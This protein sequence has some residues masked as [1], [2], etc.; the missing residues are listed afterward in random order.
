MNPIILE[1][2][3]LTCSLRPAEIIPK[4]QP[5]F[6]PNL[7]IYYLDFTLC[8]LIGNIFLILA[9]QQPDWSAAQAACVIVSAFILFR[10]T[11]FI[12]E[13][14]H[15]SKSLKGFIWY[16]NLLHGFLHKIPYY[17]YTTHR[18]HHLPETYGT[19]NDP[20]YEVLGDK[21][22]FYNLFFA[23]LILMALQPVFMMVRWGIMP[24][25]LPFIGK[26]ARMGI[27]T[28][29]SA[30]A[31]NIR[32]QRPAPSDVEKKDW[33]MQDAC[34]LFYSAVTVVLFVAGYLP[35]NLLAIWY[36]SVYLIS[37]VNYYRTML[38]H[39]YFTGFDSTNHKQQVIDSITYVLTPFNALFFPVGLGYH[40]LHHMF[41]QIPY[42]NMGKVHNVLMHTL[43]EDHPYRVTLINSYRAGLRELLAKKF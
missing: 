34:C 38:N 4:I 29:A 5:F 11:V 16:Y 6:A 24:L 3:K 15:L 27:Y 28:Y 7:V 35:S 41:P 31:M 13:T 43:P 36:V 21:S 40:A 1:K 10:A 18:Y 42:H 17:G 25:F 23:P 2:D 37:V 19:M 14:Y 12:H 39:R 26:K 9:T 22:K 20:E 30:L 8:C 33:Y 32:Y